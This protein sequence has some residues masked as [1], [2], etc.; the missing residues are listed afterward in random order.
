MAREELR[1]LLV[2]TGAY[3]YS[4]RQEF[5]LSSGRY[6]HFYINCKMLTMQR[7]AAEWIAEVFEAYI[8]KTAQAAGGLT[9]GADPIAYALR[10]FCQRPLSVFVVRKA[11][12]GHG[13]DK[14]IEGPTKAGMNVVVVDDVVTTGASTI[15]A[16]D[17]CRRAKLA[18]VAVVVLVDR[19]EDDG[20]GSI[21]KKVGAS[22]PVRSIFT[23]SELHSRWLELN[24]HGHAHTGRS[25]AAAG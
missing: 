19:E 15:T 5:R 12:K 23:K 2:A 3:Q 9:M 1:D 24:P 16:I 22:V 4:D 18:V 10:D 14:V 13:L 6:S 7:E 25:R 21:R 17:E 11:P 20:V 8:P